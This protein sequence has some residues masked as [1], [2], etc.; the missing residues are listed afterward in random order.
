VEGNT[1]TKHIGVQVSEH[2]FRMVKVALAERGQ[3]VR[4][5]VIIALGTYLDVPKEDVDKEVNTRERETI[6]T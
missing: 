2:F 4:D 5:A 3:S 1:T 6:S